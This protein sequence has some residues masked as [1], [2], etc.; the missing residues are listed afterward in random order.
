MQMDTHRLFHW[1]RRGWNLL[2]WGT[3]T[4]LHNSHGWWEGVCTFH[5]CVFEMLGK[6]FREDMVN[7]FLKGITYDI[8]IFFWSKG[9]PDYLRKWF[10]S[11]TECY[12][13]ENY[14]DRG[15]I[16]EHSFTMWKSLIFEV[17]NFCVCLIS[18][19]DQWVLSSP[20]QPIW[21][22]LL[23]VNFPMYQT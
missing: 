20:Q 21:V 9:R 14:K 13:G 6:N 5:L 3:Q 19:Y 15:L 1:C 7:V 22:L 8:Y 17:L 2:F 12:D 23:F 10:L 18:I 11:N 16:P 4:K